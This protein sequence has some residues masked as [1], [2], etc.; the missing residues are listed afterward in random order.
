MYGTDDGGLFVAPF[1]LDRLR[2][3]GTPVSLGEQL[4]S[5]GIQAFTLSKSG[6]LVMSVG[7]PNAIGRPSRWSGLIDRP[8]DAGRHRLEVPAHGARKQSWLGAVA[9]RI[10]ALDRALDPAGDDIWVKPLPTGAPYRISFDPQSDFRP[11]WTSNGRFITF[12]TARAKDGLYAHRA[13]GAGADSLLVRGTIDEGLPSPD[14]RWIVLRQ[15]SV[16]A[17]AGGRN[18]TGVRVGTDTT[19][20]PVLQP[21]R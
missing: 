20:I 13:D 3:T 12:I 16:G 9:R 5:G 8:A 6:T 10:A 15:G 19:P 7:G 1:D 2:I 18:I 17:I 11:R 4:S 21:F 14:D